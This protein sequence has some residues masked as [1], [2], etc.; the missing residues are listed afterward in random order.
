MLVSVSMSVTV[1]GVDVGTHVVCGGDVGN[2]VDGVG[3][4]G[5][6]GT[7]CGDVGWFGR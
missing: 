1:F 6:V 5:G 4:G 7:Y 3:G 2:V